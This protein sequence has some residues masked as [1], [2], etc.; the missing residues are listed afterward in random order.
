VGIWKDAREFLAVREE[1]QRF[2]P[3]MSRE[4]RERLFAGWQRA[5]H[6]A[7][8]WARATHATLL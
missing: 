3:T 8:Q 6:A 1:P 7:I 4:E 2:D 5:V